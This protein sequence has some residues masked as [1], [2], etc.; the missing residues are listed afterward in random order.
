MNSSKDAFKDNGAHFSYLSFIELLKQM[1]QTKKAK[2]IM[3]KKCKDYY[4]CN[5]KELEKIDLFHSTY[6]ADQAINWYTR[7]CFVY[8]LVNQAF[9][10]EDVSLWYLFRF[11]I[12][13]LCTQLENV[14]R[15][16]NIQD[17]LK[18]YRGQARMPTQEL[19]DLR[20]NIGG[21]IL[22]NAFF[23]TSKEITVAQQFIEGAENNDDFKVVMFEI[24]VNTPYLRSTV[25]VDIDQYQRNN[26]RK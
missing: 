25:F 4:R 19:E 6:T 16:Q 12:I 17:C 3:L 20:S 13:D 8:R 14:Y 11:F 21:C 24:I 5:T 22:T 1:P 18:L 26:W 9:R 2:E 23:S 10:I 7:D 15:K